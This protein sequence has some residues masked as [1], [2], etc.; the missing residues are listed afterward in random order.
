MNKKVQKAA[1]IVWDYFK[2]NQLLK[3]VDAIVVFRSKK[4]MLLSCFA[5]MMFRWHTILLSYAK[6]VGHLS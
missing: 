2:P 5:V 1:Q 3:K 6:M 4:S